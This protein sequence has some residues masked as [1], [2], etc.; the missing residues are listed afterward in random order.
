MDSCGCF[1]F[2][3]LHKP[4][5]E[6]QSSLLDFLYLTIVIVYVCVCP[7]VCI[8]HSVMSNSLQ[9]HGV[10]PTRLFCPWDFPGNNT[11]VG[12]HFL[13]QGIFPTQGLSPGLLHCHQILYHLSHQGLYVVVVL[14]N[15]RFN[16]N[17]GQEKG[18]Q[19][20]ITYQQQVKENL[21]MNNMYFFLKFSLAFFLPLF[22]LISSFHL[23]TSSFTSDSSIRL[24]FLCRGVE[25]SSMQSKPDQGYK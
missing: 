23:I 17:R 4:N 1:L 19:E 8:S 5:C 11:G 16:G 6:T 14:Q 9:P 2:S 22:M 12:C 18:R 20:T 25:L 10:Q 15:R 13:L 7:C 3:I 21:K 24:Q